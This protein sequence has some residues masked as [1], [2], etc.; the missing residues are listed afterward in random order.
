M[1][2]KPWNL[3]TSTF[4]SIDLHCDL[5]LGL[6]RHPTFCNGH[7]LVFTWGKRCTANLHITIYN[8][9]L[10]FCKENWMH[11]KF[12]CLFKTY[13][14]IFNIIFYFDVR[15]TSSGSQKNNWFARGFAWEYLRSCPGYAPGQSVKIRS[16][17]CSLHA[18]KNFLFARC[19]FF[20]SDVISGGLFGHLGQLHLALGANR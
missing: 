2:L 8:V 15:V 12:R 13:I 17:S 19:G 18:K 3:K 10:L 16:K 4:L 7:L 11:L 20:V 5:I 6:F 14:L 1:L 9:F